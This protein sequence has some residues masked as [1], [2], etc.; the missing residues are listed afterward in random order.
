MRLGGSALFDNMAIASYVC[1]CMRVCVCVHVCVC[2][3]SHKQACK[4]ERETK[5]GGN[6]K[7]ANTEKGNQPGPDLGSFCFRGAYSS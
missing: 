5:G 1:V 3:C 4:L 7:V 2:A 6:G